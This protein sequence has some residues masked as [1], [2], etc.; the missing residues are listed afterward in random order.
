ML[1]ISHFLKKSLT[2]VVLGAAGLSLL[3]SSAQAET[4]RERTMLNSEEVLN[5]LHGVLAETFESILE[6]VSQRRIKR[7]APELPVFI[8][9]IIEG[10]VLLYE[11]Q[12]SLKGADASTALVDDAGF[13]FGKHAVGLGKASRS[14]WFTLD[15]GGWKYQTYCSSRYPFVVCSLLQE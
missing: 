15:L 14:G 12:S 13:S 10:K 8:V 9:E 4:P 5:V 6:K 7:L 11:G 2:S 1:K 3:S